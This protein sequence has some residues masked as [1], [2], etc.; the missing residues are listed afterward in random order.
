MTVFNIEG[1]GWRGL[2]SIWGGG[3]HWLPGISLRQVGSVIEN[4]ALNLSYALPGPTILPE[5]A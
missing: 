5:K 3:L 4:S 2:I 1:G